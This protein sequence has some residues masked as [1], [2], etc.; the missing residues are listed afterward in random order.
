MLKEKIA[1]QSTAVLNTSVGA[2]GRVERNRA[3]VVVGGVGASPVAA[4]DRQNAVTRRAL[5][6]GLRSGPGRRVGRVDTGRQRTGVGVVEV[7][8]GQVNIPVGVANLVSNKLEQVGTAV[9]ATKRGKTPVSTQ[10]SNNRVV[11][12]EGVIG[13]TLHAV[14]DGAANQEAVDAV[15]RGVGADLIEGDQNQSVLHEVRV[16]KQRGQ[17]VV[18]VFA[19]ECHVGVVSI[20]GH[21]GSE[22]TVLGQSLGV[23][24][25]VER[26]VVL[27]LADTGVR[28]GNG[29]VQHH[30]VVL[31]DVVVRAS[32]RPAE[33]LVSSVRQVLLVLAPERVSC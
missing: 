5:A 17:E 33:A 30:G 8:I 24:I 10:G 21:V 12:V 6:A 9:P 7:D 26:G 28:L 19:G 1:Y 23:Q 14:G 16:V 15:R 27:D 13:S 4:D 3:G 18:Q 2:T 32:L 25:I 31:A 20:V 29:V 22:E 11:G